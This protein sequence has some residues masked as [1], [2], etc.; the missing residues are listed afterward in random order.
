MKKL[1]TTIVIT[2]AMFL[3]SFVPTH[4]VAESIKENKDTSSQNRNSK[5]EMIHVVK[6]DESVSDI[7][8]HYGVALPDLIDKNNIKDQKVN[9]GD[10]LVLPKTLSSQEKDLMA[11]LVHA[12]AKG[13]PFEGKVGVAVVVLNRVDS[14]KFPNTV[15]EVIKAKGQFSP[16]ANGSIN[17]PASAESKKAVNQAIALQHTSTKATFFYNPKK[18]NDKWIKS[19]P[20]ISRIGNH[21]FAVS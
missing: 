4:G 11:R 15:T 20:V 16:V 21:N 6:E 3:T 10:V 17:K 8:I 19:L 14:E 2:A 9:K 5:G 13:E 12:E 7:A 18:T 1:L